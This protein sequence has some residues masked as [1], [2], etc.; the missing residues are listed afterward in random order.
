MLL[1]RAHKGSEPPSEE[2]SAI[3]NVYLAECL[4]SV[5]VAL[6]QS[7]ERNLAPSPSWWGCQG[8]R[9]LSNRSHPIDHQEQGAVNPNSSP[10]HTVQAASPG[11]AFSTVK[12][13]LPTLISAI[14]R[15]PH[16]NGQRPVS[17][18]NLDASLSLSWN[19]CLT[20]PSSYS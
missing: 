7:S 18:V 6:I 3:P 13:S 12:M 19:N 10:L 14:K 2:F 1:V 4:D 20:L 11:S 15:I 8:G 16:R 5:P 9:S 17:Q